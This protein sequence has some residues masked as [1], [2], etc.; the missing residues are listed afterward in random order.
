MN[1]DDPYVKYAMG[2]ELSDSELLSKVVGCDLDTSKKLLL[3]ANNS[4][5]ALDGLSIDLLTKVPKIGHKQAL[6][7]K[8]IRELNLR[9]QAEVHVRVKIRSAIDVHRY[10]S[11]MGDLE[12]EEMHVILLNRANMILRSERM[13]IGGVASV[14]ADMTVVARTAIQYLAS[15]VILIHNHPS[16][17]PD[18]SDADKKLTEKMKNALKLCDINLLDH[19][20]IGQDRYYSF[21]DN[22]IL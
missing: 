6:K 15:G 4:L 2:R 20:I 16:G 22:G 11:Y 21:A 17:D 5:K 19:V 9:K 10:Y 3:A 13:F 12:V 1:L 14:I 8:M 18:P 7:I